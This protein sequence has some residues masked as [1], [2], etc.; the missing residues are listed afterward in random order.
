MMSIGCSSGLVQVTEIFFKIICHGMCSIATMA[1]YN[2]K[3]KWLDEIA[4]ILPD[5]SWWVTWWNAR[6]YHMF[7]AF[8]CL[9]YVNVTLAESGN[10]TLKELTQLWL[11]E[12]AQDNT[13][14]MLTQIHEFNSFLTHITS[15]S[16]ELCSL[17]HDRA[18]RAIQI[19]AAKAYVIEFT[20]KHVHREAI[21]ENANPQ[22]FVLSS[23][24]RHRP[25]NSRIGIKE[26]LCKKRNRRKHLSIQ[27]C[28]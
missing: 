28:M 11:L 18:N 14:T 13:S 7:P 22:V 17:T 10:S 23:C 27:I 4:N 12:A 19:G 2:N 5:I 26:H 9:G 21:E 1:E 6:Q 25:V 8:R 24:A 16:K 15:S 20:N 3:K